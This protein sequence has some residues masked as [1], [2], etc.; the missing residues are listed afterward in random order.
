[1]N[2]GN[3]LGVFGGFGVG[4]D[5]GSLVVSLVGAAVVVVGCE[6]GARLI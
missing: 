1:L 3:L 4:R 2:V 6:E 5:V